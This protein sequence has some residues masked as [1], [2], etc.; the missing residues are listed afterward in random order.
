MVPH[1]ASIFTYYSIYVKLTNLLFLY[2]LTEC[3]E[4]DALELELSEITA[5]YV[6]VSLL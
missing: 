4:E 3:P 5:R 2:Q 6:S 1:Q